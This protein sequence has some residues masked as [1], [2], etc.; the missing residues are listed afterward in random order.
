MMITIGQLAKQMGIRT[1]TL[2]YYE[3][4]GLIQPNG[5]TEAGYR[6]YAPTAAD[7][8]HFIQRAQRLG[9]SLADIRGLLT[10]WESGDLNQNDLLATAEARYLALEQQATKTLILR[11]EL[12]HFLQDLHGRTQTPQPTNNTFS[13]LLGRVCAN[14]HEQ[15]T[16]RFMLDWLLTQ[17]GCHLSTA[18]GQALIQQLRGQHV[19]IWQEETH[20]HI[21]IVSPEPAVGQA[22]HQLAQLEAN[23]HTHNTIHTEV[24]PNPEGFLF[25]VSGENAFIFARLFLALEQEE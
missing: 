6:L 2:R 13:Q 17:H 18:E 9:F 7:R 16:S 20:Y 11:H 24:T 1:S 8:I 5:R 15:T 14:P 19:H 10:G 23:C 4:E 25:T 12:A 21:L 3:K 22:L